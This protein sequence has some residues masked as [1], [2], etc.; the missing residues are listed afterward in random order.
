[1]FFFSVGMAILLSFCIGQLL[2]KYANADDMTT[3]VLVVS[4]FLITLG[5]LLQLPSLF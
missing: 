4:T 5:F 1:M 3:G 2:E